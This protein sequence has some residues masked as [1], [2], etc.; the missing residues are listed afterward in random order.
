MPEFVMFIVRLFV[1]GFFAIFPTVACAIGLAFALLPM[2]VIPLNVVRQKA[3]ERE[4]VTYTNPQIEQRIAREHKTIY[5]LGTNI[6]WIIFG[7]LP[8]FWIVWVLLFMLIN[9]N[10]FN[11]VYYI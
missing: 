7:L 11:I 8:F 9:I 10:P 1:S 3:L 2:V 6:I 5:F 4:G